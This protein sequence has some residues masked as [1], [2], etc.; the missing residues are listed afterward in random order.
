MQA[1]HKYK[2]DHGNTESPAESPEVFVR[3]PHSL[4]C[5]SAQTKSRNKFIF[6]TG[7][8]QPKISDSGSLTKSI[9]V[10]SQT[11]ALTNS[12]DWQT[13]TWQPENTI[14]ADEPREN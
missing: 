10:L 6:G 3:E 11:N 9:H 7:I 8:S 12:V 14:A 2:K 4:R 1:Y 13:R 5:A